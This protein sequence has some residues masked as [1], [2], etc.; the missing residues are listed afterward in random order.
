MEDTFNIETFPS[1][2][3]LKQLQIS[4]SAGKMKFPM[5]KCMHARYLH[6]I[7]PYFDILI[8]FTDNT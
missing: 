4:R 6:L 1:L 7:S 8:V 2:W 5:Q 3:R